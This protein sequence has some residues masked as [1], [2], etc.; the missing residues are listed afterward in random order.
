MTRTFERFLRSFADDELVRFA[1]ARAGANPP[2][3]RVMQ[4]ALRVEADRRGI[5]LDH[6]LFTTAVPTDDAP[7]RRYP[8]R[9]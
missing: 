1:H 5:R 7:A 2:Y 8:P 9:A 3:W 6:E 4:F